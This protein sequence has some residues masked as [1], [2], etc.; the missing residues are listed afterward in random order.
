MKITAVI[1]MIALIAMIGAWCPSCGGGGGGGDSTETPTDL[2]SDTGGGGDGGGGDTTTKDDPIANALARIAINVALKTGLGLSTNDEVLNRAHVTLLNHNCGNGGC[3]FM[4]GDT[5][6]NCSTDCVCGDGVCDASESALACPADCGCGNGSCDVFAGE[7]SVTCPVDCQPVCGDMV[8]SAEEYFT[9]GCLADCAFMLSDYIG[10]DPLPMV[11]GMPTYK[12]IWPTDKESGTIYS[13]GDGKAQGT[14]I[15]G[16]GY[17]ANDP[18][19]QDVAAIFIDVTL[20][21]ADL[22]INGYTVTCTETMYNHD[23]ME[24]S[25][26]LV[27]QPDGTLAFHT[28]L[29]GKVYAYRDDPPEAYTIVGSA[30]SGTITLPP[31]AAH[32]TCVEE[33]GMYAVTG[34]P[35]QYRYGDLTV[36]YDVDGDGVHDYDVAYLETDGS[37][38]APAHEI[39]Q[40][41]AVD[42]T[43]IRLDEGFGPSN[44]AVFFDEDGNGLAACDDPACADHPLCQMNYCPDKGETMGYNH[45]AYGAFAP[46]PV[47]GDGVC[48]YRSEKA[49]CPADCTCGNGLCEAAAG[50]DVVTCPK[51]CV[52]CGDG[53]CSLYE[54]NRGDCSADCCGDGKC[55]VHDYVGGCLLDCQ[56]GDGV[57]NGP[58]EEEGLIMGSNYCMGDC[59]GDGRCSNY[60]YE[61]EACLEDCDCGDGI[62]NFPAETGVHYCVADCCGDGR[63][64]WYEYVEGCPE[65]CECGDGVCNADVE[66]SAEHYCADDC[67]DDGQ[68]TFYES[69]SG[70]CPEDCCG[71]GVCVMAENEPSPKYCAADCCGDGE[72]ADYEVVSGACP[73][74]CGVCGN[75]LCEPSEA[76]NSPPQYCEI[77]CCGDTMCSVAERIGGLCPADCGVCGTGGCEM[78][79][80]NILCPLDCWCG[81]TFCN[82][83][84]EDVLQQYCIIDCRGNGTCEPNEIAHP[85][86]N[87]VPDCGVCGDGVCFVHESVTCPGDCACGDAVCDISESSWLDAYCP[88]DCCVDDGVFSCDPNEIDPDHSELYCAADCCGNDTCDVHESNVNCAADCPL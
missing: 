24:G 50:E 32:K 75:E 79:E 23:C 76:Q 72:C 74:D 81:N 36:T 44:P 22:P 42:W 56:C 83:G 69:Y 48:D 12:C 8:C 64:T 85:E 54:Q 78:N 84:E 88:E 46:C 47:C 34:C 26:M 45:H 9:S 15:C 52:E 1:P 57:C 77:D 53:F 58:V 4:A 55:T 60:E 14:G 7:S 6:A 39:C 59:C 66:N 86:L 28:A 70:I 30:A 16:Y 87:W 61:A 10:M 33:Y 25:A 51:D 41:F 43:R 5:A 27:L 62:C 17:R 11:R 31:S 67:C 68:C 18:A 13:E 82:G 65:D 21:I 35:E 38:T 80:S 49:T 19:M 29:A 71:N 37:V 2:P 3:D 40:S 20:D 63:C 73:A